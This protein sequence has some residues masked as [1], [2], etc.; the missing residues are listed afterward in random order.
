MLVQVLVSLNAAKPF[1]G[2]E[3]VLYIVIKGAP[4]HS[5]LLKDS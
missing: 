1:I 3:D 2:V 5:L 4:L